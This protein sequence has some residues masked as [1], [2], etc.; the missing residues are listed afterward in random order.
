MI[1]NLKEI[2]LTEIE[3]E[4]KEY[5][6]ASER[7]KQIE[8]DISNT[9]EPEETFLPFKKYS[10]LEKKLL[11][12][13]EY[14]SYKS[15]KERLK[16][17][18]REKENDYDSKIIEQQAELDRLEKICK[19]KE[20]IKER[21]EFIKKAKTLKDLDLTLMEAKEILLVNG[22]SF[23]LEGSDK[24]I[25]ENASE[26][27]KPGDYILVHKTN[28][29]PTSNIVQS[30][31]RS[32]FTKTITISMG[33]AGGAGGDAFSYKYLDSRDTIHFALNGEV[34]SH[35]Y[36]KFDGRKY[37]VLIP[38]ERVQG[39]NNLANFN[40]VDTFFTGEVSTVGGYILCPEDEADKIQSNNPD[41]MVVGYKG[42]IVDKYA[43]GF[44]S[45]LGY[46]CEKIGEYN[47]SD[48]SD[49]EKSNSF[50]QSGSSH[51]VSP[52]YNQEETFGEYYKLIGFIEGFKEYL[53]KTKINDIEH[54][55][56]KMFSSNSGEIE[57]GSK[58]ANLYTIGGFFPTINMILKDSVSL[59]RQYDN[60]NINFLVAKLESVYGI[61]ISDDDVTLLK[62]NFASADEFCEKILKEKEKIKEIISSMINMEQIRSA[63]QAKNIYFLINIIQEMYSK[64]IN[65]QKQDE[66]LKL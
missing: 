8:E 34:N 10:S 25:I 7:I 20:K 51:G 58:K 64:Q 40:N 17:E 6:S 41:T 63:D 53:E 35:A 60:K 3:N 16:K 15:E 66:E 5:N 18:Y 45:I 29:C 23:V 49:I 44:L 62:S 26:F 31:L 38:F 37:A 61:D 56:K 48:D 55:I 4:L 42:E 11:K 27:N 36:G 46:K 33:G 50:H 47:W 12:R 52:E 13:K 43:D 57:A 32:G 30:K 19:S 24:N 14:L 59:D 65:Y 9:K 2:L 39:V 21:F 54:F 1:D 28:K 22:K